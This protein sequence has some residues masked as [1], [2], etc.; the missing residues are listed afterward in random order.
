MAVNDRIRLR[1]YTAVGD[2]KSSLDR[3]ELISFWWL[4][5]TEFE[6]LVPSDAT[7]CYGMFPLDPHV[8]RQTMEI[9]GLSLL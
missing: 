6:R 4:S 2:E 9:L 5:S 1:H 8:R 7:K 3:L